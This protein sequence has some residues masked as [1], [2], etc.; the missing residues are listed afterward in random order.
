MSL[1][2]TA[3]VDRASVPKGD[4]L[5][6]AIDALGFDCKLDSLSD[7]AE[8]HRGLIQCCEVGN[9]GVQVLTGITV[10]NVGF[11]AAP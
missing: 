8:P 5:Q 4:A 9:K 3:Y 7:S 2:Q 10:P 11:F 6:A 1:Q